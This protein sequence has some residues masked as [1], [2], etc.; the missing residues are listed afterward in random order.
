MKNSDSDVSDVWLNLS[1]IIYYVI[2]HPYCYAIHMLY[3][4][5][6]Y[7][8]IYLCL[9]THLGMKS[10]G[11][12]CDMS[13]SQC[14]K[15]FSS[16]LWEVNR[17]PQRDLHDKRS[18]AEKW[19][20]KWGGRESLTEMAGHPL[21]AGLSL[22][23]PL[24]TWWHPGCPHPSAGMLSIFQPSLINPETTPPFSFHLRICPSWLLRLLPHANRFHRQTPWILLSGLGVKGLRLQVIPHPLPLFSLHLAPRHWPSS[25]SALFLLSS[26]CCP[27]LSLHP[28]HDRGQRHTHR[29][30]ESSDLC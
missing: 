21:C 19:G 15:D 25:S 29:L 13:S 30:C 16:K 8:M 22:S 6:F 4:L 17:S 2:I 14:G 26:F 9:S 5:L 3:D 23:L 24:F 18:A 20:Q 10:W 28:D 27:S 11:S 7:D 12:A 1:L